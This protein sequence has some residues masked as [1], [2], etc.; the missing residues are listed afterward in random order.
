MDAKRE[1]IYAYSTG[2]NKI[3]LQELAKKR[4]NSISYIINFLLDNLREDKGLQNKLET[5]IPVFVKRSETWK[6]K[7]KSQLRKPNKLKE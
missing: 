1:I 2:K 6:T 3:F 5:Y 7:N 4:G